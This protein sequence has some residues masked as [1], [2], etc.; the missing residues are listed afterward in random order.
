MVDQTAGLSPGL[1]CDLRDVRV[2]ER[3]GGTL[4]DSELVRGLVLSQKTANISGPRK[5][6]KPLI[7]L[8]QFCISPPKTDVSLF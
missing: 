6:E 4:E 7:G 2:I 3:L 8:I 5:V 1:S